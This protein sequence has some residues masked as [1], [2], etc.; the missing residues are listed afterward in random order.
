[1]SAFTEEQQA[2]L[3]EVFH[4]LWNRV[5]KLRIHQVADSRRIEALTTTVAGHG[6]IHIG[7]RDRILTAHEYPPYPPPNNEQ[8]ITDAILAGNLNAFRRLFDMP[9]WRDEPEED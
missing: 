9:G 4:H 7:E 5:E 6:L 3:R 1:M 8:E 2:I